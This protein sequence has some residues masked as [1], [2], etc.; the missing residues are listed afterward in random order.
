[1]K[2]KQ[3]ITINEIASMAGVS[4]TTVSRYLNGKYEFMSEETKIRIASVIENNQYQPNHVARSLKTKS[5][6]LIGVIVSDIENPFAAPTI[7]SMNQAFFEKRINMLVASSNNSVMLEKDI[8]ESMIE[9]RVDAIL[10]NPVSY[11]SPHIIKV[12]HDIPV[13]L[14][15][16]AIKDIKLDIVVSDNQSTIREAVEHLK[17]AGFSTI[18]LLTEPYAQ[19]WTRYERVSSFRQC[20]LALGMN[21]TEIDSHIFVSEHKDLEAIE[22]NVDTIL[23]RNNHGV[24][25]ILA[26]NGPLFLG[27]ALTARQ[28]N[29]NIPYQLGLLGFDDFGNFS[30]NGWT[31]LPYVTLSSLAPNWEKV[32]R[33]LVKL[34]LERIEKPDGAKK[35][36]S[37]TVNL[38]IAQ[39][40]QLLK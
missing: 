3:K 30:S 34:A 1:M 19:I 13:I 32:G 37:V 7:K 12:S 27:L 31:R 18:Y 20:M 14:I 33:E 24:P 15:D 26:T 25:A 2:N 17:Y 4:K 38:K 10:I 6:R 22:K 16:R 35:F 8:L 21:E 9:Q 29:L 40:T 11:D 5:T 39:S 28:M 36:V 23:K